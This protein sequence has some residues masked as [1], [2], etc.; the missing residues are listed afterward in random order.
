[1]ESILTPYLPLALLFL[2]A[3]VMSLAIIVVTRLLGPRRPSALKS[4]PFESGSEPVGT[5]RDRF[6]VKFYMVGLLFIVFDVEAVFMYPWAVL[7]QEL[8]WNVFISMAIF[9]STLLIGLVYVWKKG[10]LDWT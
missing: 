7:L 8:G 9:V 10:A 3:A 6:S 5:A 4:S 1:M 2:L